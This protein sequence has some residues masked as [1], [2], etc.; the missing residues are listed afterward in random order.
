M[1]LGIIFAI[2]SPAIYAIV[3]Y[4]DKFFLE[5]Y[6]ISP[7]VI[8]IY[9]G[10]IAFTTSIILILLFGLHFFS[11]QVT[12]AILF[13]GVLTELY[14]LPYFAAL[15]L[16][17]ASTVMPLV[18]FVPLFV[19]I[20]DAYILGEKLST[21]QYLGAGLIIFSGLLLSIERVNLYFIRPR[22]AFWYML[23]ACL[24]IALA[25][26]LF[27]Y[28]VGQQSFWTILPYEGM[29]IFFCA[30]CIL[31][32]PKN[33]RLFKKETKKLPLKLF[34]LMSFNEAIFIFAR[35]CGFFALAFISASLMGVLAGLQPLFVLFY[36]LLLSILFPKLLKEVFSK[37]TFFFKLSAI[38]LTI[39]G[40]AFLIY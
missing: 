34:F 15:S 21:T 8:T 31:L 11:L 9:S 18:Q 29:G 33:L 16:E 22:K 23:T 35:Y 3:N 30:L 12:I 26:L 40:V 4:F 24:Y 36:G 27:K 6:N 7:V 39:V 17:D 38:L 5:R 1:F 14:I 10:I 13:S 28:A 2:L 25:T 32:W 19:I 20:G 37:K